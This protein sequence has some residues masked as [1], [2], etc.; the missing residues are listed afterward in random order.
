MARS[1]RWA[2]VLGGVLTLV[3]LPTLLGALPARSNR[4]TA[5]DLVQQI[6]AS[7]SLSYSG[8][9]ESAGSL[10]LPV[11]RQFNSLADLFGGRTQLRVWWRGSVDW[12]LDSI[13]LAGETDVRTDPYGSW[14]WDYESNAA[15]HTDP[16]L[17]ADIRL[18]SAADLL[19]ANLGRRLLSEAVPSE[20]TRLPSKRIAGRDA[21][22]IRLRPA[23]PQSTVHRVD[24]W[25]DTATG[26]P[27]RVDVFGDD[28]RNAAL[29]TTFLDFSPSPPAAAATG[30]LFPPGAQVRAGARVD[31]ATALDQLGGQSAPNRLAGFA[32][33]DLLRDGSIGWYGR[34]VTTF[35]AAPLTNRLANSIRRQLLDTPGVITTANGYGVTVGPLNL[36]L[37]V[38][39][40]TGTSWLLTGTVTSNT[41]WAAAAELRGTS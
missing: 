1:W 21:P 23:A 41:L 5:V 27:L 35:A 40:G 33:T 24:V 29:T 38:S 17:N 14:T 15:V 6:K 36:I 22:G 26:L 2:P 3:L 11:T 18:P 34:G 4:A 8:Y 28:D 39:D 31:V 37:S 7:G 20:L 19:P 30:F 9:A 13:S 10:A 25:A 16:P 12:R 32:K